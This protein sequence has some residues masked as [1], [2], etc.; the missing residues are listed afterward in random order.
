MIQLRHTVLALVEHHPSWRW[1]PHFQ[2]CRTRLR[3]RHGFS[4]RGWPARGMR[5]LASPSAESLA[6][7]LPQL[8]CS[9]I[10]SL[11]PY[12]DVATIDWNT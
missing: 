3:S 9:K 4:H 7:L 10:S 11:H 5:S 1:C 12:D 2:G 6:D 8:C